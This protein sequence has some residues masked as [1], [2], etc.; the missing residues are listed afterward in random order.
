[1]SQK[2][3]RLKSRIGDGEREQPSEDGMEVMISSHSARRI[4][5]VHAYGLF[6]KEGGK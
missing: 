1:M 4:I 3:R 6:L 2:G 5:W